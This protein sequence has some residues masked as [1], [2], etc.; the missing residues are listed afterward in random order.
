[1]FERMHTF[2]THVSDRC[3]FTEYLNSD[4]AMMMIHSRNTRYTVCKC[5]VKI[6]R[7]TVL[8]LHYKKYLSY[9]VV[10]HKGITGSSGLN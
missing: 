2:I 5:V 1:M 4:S 8:V 6:H 7:T 9:L 10:G 3:S